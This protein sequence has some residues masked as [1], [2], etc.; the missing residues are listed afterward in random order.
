MKHLKTQI[1]KQER[2]SHK[3]SQSKSQNEKKEN[4]KLIGEN[5]QII[6]QGKT[7]KIKAEFSI[8][9]LGQEILE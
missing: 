2:I 9:D 4:I 3:I 6:Y 8:Q 1:H 5:H 7:L